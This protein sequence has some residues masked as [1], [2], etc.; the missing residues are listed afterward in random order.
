MKNT[1]VLPIDRARLQDRTSD[2]GQ[3][4][5]SYHP[6]LLFFQAP[7]PFFPWAPFA[8]RDQAGPVIFF[9]VGG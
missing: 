5:K 7:G 2:D 8:F 1:P 9:S 3:H 6:G 4:K